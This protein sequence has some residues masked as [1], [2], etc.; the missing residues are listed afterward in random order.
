MILVSLGN[1]YRRDDAVGPVILERF[2]DCRRYHCD[3]DPL[4]LM[5]ALEGE[6]TALLVDAMEGEKPGRIHRWTWGE[7]PPEKFAPRLSSHALSLFSILEL[8]GQ[9]NRLPRRVTV[10]ALEGEDFSWG[11]GFTPE[12]EASLDE[13]E[14]L[15]REDMARSPVCTNCL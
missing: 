7:T 14:K 15:I 11:Q 5:A 12:V 9:S 3:G 6:E 1:I 10:F 2:C 8:L 4:G 13:L